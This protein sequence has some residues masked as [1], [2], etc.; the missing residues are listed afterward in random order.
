M[1]FLRFPMRSA[2]RIADF[3]AAILAYR[4]ID[5]KMVR[6]SMCLSVENGGANRSR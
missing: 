1:I 4:G 3:G 2:I 5:V 6:Y